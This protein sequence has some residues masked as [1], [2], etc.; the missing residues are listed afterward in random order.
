VSTTP[1]H[2]RDTVE[3]APTDAVSRSSRVPLVSSSQR[4][5]PRQRMWLESPRPASASE[6][7][8]CRKCTT[9]RCLTWVFGSTDE[10]VDERLANH[11]RA[12]HTDHP[13]GTVWAP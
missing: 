2:Q 4:L 3:R 1:K 5:G 6:P 13:E 12:F 10:E 11:R 9:P 8:M 7:R